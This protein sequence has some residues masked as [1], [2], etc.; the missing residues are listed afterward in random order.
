MMGWTLGRLRTITSPIGLLTRWDDGKFELMYD[1]RA[2]S[3]NGHALAAGE[4][5]Y[6]D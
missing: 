1:R 5:A 3:G 4:L 2:L 6:R